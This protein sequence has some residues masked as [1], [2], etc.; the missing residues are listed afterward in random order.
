M[1]RSAR[2]LAVGAGLISPHIVTAA[3]KLR[4]SPPEPREVGGPGSISVRGTCW[5]RPG[6]GRGRV[7]ARRG[8]TGASIVLPAVTSSAGGAREQFAPC[9]ALVCP[10]GRS[11]RLVAEADQSANAQAG[12][13]SSTQRPDQRPQPNASRTARRPPTRDGEQRARCA[14]HRSRAR[15]P[16]TPSTQRSTTNELAGT[17]A[18]ARWQTSP[19]QRLRAPQT[20]ARLPS[21]RVD[22]PA[23]RSRISPTAT[24]VLGC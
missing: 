14:T 1:I 22:M 12:D 24:P 6:S 7:R 11:R 19:T 18:H 16:G 2:D 13:S 3:S 15:S 5:R 10:E 8:G 20:S 4:H 21:A 23:R 9:Q 17:T